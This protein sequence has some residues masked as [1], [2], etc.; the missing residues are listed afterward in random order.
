MKI[1]QT[2]AQFDENGPYMQKMKDKQNVYLNF[3]TF[4]LSYLTL[5]KYYG[6]ITMYCNQKAY[7]TFIK[8]IP[9]DEIIIKENKNDFFFWNMYKIDMMKLQNEDFIHVDSDVFIFD[10]L[11][12]NFIDGHYDMMVQDIIPPSENFVKDFYWDNYSYL[13]NG[14]LSLSGSYDNRCVSCG[15][16]G[17]KK[18]V[19]DNYFY[20]VDI[21]HDAMKRKKLKSVNC[22]TMI[23]EEFMAYLVALKY[24]YKIYD[25]LPYDLVVKHNVRK[26]GDIVK[27]THLWTNSKFKDDMV[28]KVKN[29]IKKDFPDKFSL[30]NFYDRNIYNK[31]R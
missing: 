31:V 16:F 6:S 15:T 12:K 4:L 1:F 27:Y 3:Y 11:F 20:I 26:V 8:Y 28:A 14:S 13:T 18:H 30:V 9:Y 21:I 2:F 22:Q 5:N 17:M 23:L 10:D 24:N 19:L 25:I 29:K 7:D